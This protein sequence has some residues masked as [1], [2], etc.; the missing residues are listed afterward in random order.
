MNHIFPWESKLK[1]T[2]VDIKCFFQDV[3]SLLRKSM[4]LTEA[5]YTT[6]QRSKLSFLQQKLSVYSQ[7]QCSQKIPPYTF[8]LYKQSIFDPRPENC[9]NFHKKLP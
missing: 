8:F 3:K 9:S 6:S 4:C 7:K 1:H 5:S 2:V